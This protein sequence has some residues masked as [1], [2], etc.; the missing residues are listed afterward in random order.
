M[1]TFIPLFIQKEG[2]KAA[3]FEDFTSFEDKSRWMREL[4]QAQREISTEHYKRFNGRILSVLLMQKV[5]LKGIF[6]EKVMNLS[7]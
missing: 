3:E 2:T 1:T 6:Q 7:L 5:K 4:L